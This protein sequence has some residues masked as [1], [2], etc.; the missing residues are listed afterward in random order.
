M[1][2]TTRRISWTSSAGDEASIGRRVA[3][4]MPRPITATAIS[5]LFFERFVMALKKDHSCDIHH[6]KACEQADRNG[7]LQK[8]CPDRTAEGHLA[9]DLHDHLRDRTD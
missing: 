6:D 8:P 7:C 5:M 9:N 1:S 3:P 4:R 2:R